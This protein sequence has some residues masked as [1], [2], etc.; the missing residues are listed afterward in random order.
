[1]AGGG[2]PMMAGGDPAAEAAM[3]EQAM[4]K[5]AAEE[6]QKA[7]SYLDN[8]FKVDENEKLR[9]E[10]EKLKSQLNDQNQ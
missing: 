6:L 3:M 10:N 8:Q 1:M 2:D 4:G 9:S 5:G 7:A